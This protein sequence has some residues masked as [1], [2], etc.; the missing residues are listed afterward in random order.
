MLS[1][2]IIFILSAFL[3]SS[4]VTGPEGYFKKSANNKLFDR[5]GFK[6]GKRAPLYNKK[7]IVKAKQNVANND[8]EDDEEEYDSLLENENISQANRD[9]YRRILEQEVESKYL[10]KGRKE[11]TNKAYPVLVR[12]SSRP[13]NYR[14]PTA[15]QIERTGV[16]SS[17]KIQ[18]TKK[19]TDDDDEIPVKKELEPLQKSKETDSLPG[20]T[21]II[22]PVKSI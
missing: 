1:K 20:S 8:Y 16:K 2:A 7:Y 4:C 18:S 12:N 21:T 22:H 14:C 9:M 5:K 6:N 19:A 3:L 10:G 15:Q 11:K 13:D 17:I